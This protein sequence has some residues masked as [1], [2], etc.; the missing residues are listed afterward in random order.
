M[1]RLRFAAVPGLALL[2]AGP[3]RAEPE[4]L[5]TQ[6]MRATVKVNHEKSA[7][8]GFILTRPDPHE[9]RRRQFV[10]VTAAHV[11]EKIPG[12]DATVFFRTKEGEGVYKKVPTKVVLRKGGKPQWARHPSQDVAALVVV[13]P[14]RADL[15]A[16]TADLLAT[17]RELRRYRVGPGDVLAFLGYPHR[18]EASE[19]GFPVLRSGPVASFPLLPTAVTKTF[20]LSGNVFEGDSGGPVYLASP[21]RDL[22][23]KEDPGEVRLIVGLVTGQHFLDEEMKMVYGTTRLRHRL[24]L[25]VVVHAAFIRETLQRLP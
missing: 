16:L 15:P 18:L 25:A 12:D 21:R 19:A 17:D 2:L 1:H 3:L 22:P 7:G 6:L 5:P 14:D 24:D 23:G 11:L 8:S 9:A 10:L 20:L 13:P 4:D